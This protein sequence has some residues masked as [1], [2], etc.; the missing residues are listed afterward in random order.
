MFACL[1]VFVC[2]SSFNVI[3]HVSVLLSLSVWLPVCLESS[4]CSLWSNSRLTDVPSLDRHHTNYARPLFIKLF[5]M[6]VDRIIQM[7]LVIVGA[8]ILWTQV[9][10]QFIPQLRCHFNSYPSS[11]L[12]S[13]HTPAQVSPQ[14]IPQLKSHL[15]SYPSSSLTSVHTPAQ[16]L[17]QF[18]PQLKSH[19]N[20]YP[21]SSLTSIYIPIIWFST[22]QFST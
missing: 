21:S 4:K 2:I 13:I 11:S 10:P 18:I 12:T 15:S 20:L 7:V 16:V 3:N 8:L 17:P 6:N 1:S 5:I 19:L 14:F 22:F 9:S